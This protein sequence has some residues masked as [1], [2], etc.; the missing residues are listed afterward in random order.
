MGRLEKDSNEKGKR[1]SP[2]SKKIENGVVLVAAYY[3]HSS[4]FGHLLPWFPRSSVL[5]HRRH[6]GHHRS[7]CRDPPVL[8]EELIQTT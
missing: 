1:F 6:L 3:H 5:G 8:E 4:N 7:L 2:F